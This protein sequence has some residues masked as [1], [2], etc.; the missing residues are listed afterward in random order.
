MSQTLTV[1]DFTDAFFEYDAVE[2]CN[3]GSVMPFILNPGGTF[4]PPD[5]S[6][7]ISV[8]ERSIWVLQWQAVLIRY[9][10]IRRVVQNRILSF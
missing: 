9:C 6:A 4:L 7:L 10:T 2:Y 3:E 8:P 1:T 5:L